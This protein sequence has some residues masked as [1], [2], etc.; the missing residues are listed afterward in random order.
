MYDNDCYKIE[1]T[2]KQ[3]NLLRAMKNEKRFYDK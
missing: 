2:P 1:L 3:I